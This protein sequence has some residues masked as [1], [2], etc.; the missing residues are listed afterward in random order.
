VNV[1]GTIHLAQEA[2]RAGVRRFVFLSSIKVNGEGTAPR[3]PYRASDVP[4]PVDPYGVSKA[5]AEDGLRAI[6]RETGMEVVILRPVLVY[7]PGVKGNFHSMLRCLRK[8]IPL[9]LG[10]IHNRRSLVAR[11]NL[12]DLVVTA[13]RHP[14]AANGTFLVSDG[15]DLS[16]TDL[17][18]RAGEAL[19][20]R[21]RLLPVPA[22]LIMVV[23]RLLGR[24]EVANR[25]CGSLEVD[26]SETRTR[27][28]WT[29]PVSVNVALEETAT[30][31]A[32]RE[33]P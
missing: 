16:T 26:I 28:G 8:G 15:E 21:A 4:A 11:D 19:D 1:A 6:A 27:L 18:V 24:G 33:H 10:A 20:T 17:L 9:P 14:A 29:P 23:A 22:A 31:F 5:E 2:V 3:R 30:A 32:A 7:G 25:L 13:L 12:V